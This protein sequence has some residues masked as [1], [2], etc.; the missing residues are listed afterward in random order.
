MH[1]HS[2][3]CRLRTSRATFLIDVEPVW[4]DPD[5]DHLD[6][7]LP[8]HFWRGFIGRS[9]GTIHHD[10]KTRNRATFG[11]CGFSIFHI[12]P[13]GVINPL[14]TTDIMRFGRLNLRAEHSLDFILGLIRQFKAV[15][16]KKLDAIIVMRIMAGR[17]HNAQICAHG[18]G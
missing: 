14:C 5:R 15:R 8:Q 1:H 11:K 2:F 16:A 10:L 7:Q 18:S 3:A 9:V 12:A 17:N 6:P 4:R 13:L